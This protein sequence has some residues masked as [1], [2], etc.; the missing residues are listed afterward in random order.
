MGGRTKPKNSQPWK[1]KARRLFDT[2]QRGKKRQWG[3]EVEE[4]KHRKKKHMGGG[5]WGGGGGGGGVGV[6]KKTH[7]EGDLI[8]PKA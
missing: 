7:A 1:A 2:K 5:F 4:G 3:G 8:D 6:G